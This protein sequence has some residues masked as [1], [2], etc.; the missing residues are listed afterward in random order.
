MAEPPQSLTFAERYGPWALVTGGSEGVGGSW[1]SAIAARGVNV[2]LL[3]RRPDVLEAKATELR[4]EHGVDVRTLSV[5]ITGSDLLERLDEVTHDL[6]V[7][8]LVHNVGSVERNHGWFLDDSLDVTVKTIGDYHT[9]ALENSHSALEGMRAVAG[10]IVFMG[11]LTGMAGQPLEA[12]YS[13]AKAFSQVFAEALWSE[14]VN[15]VDVVSVPSVVRARRRSKPRACSR[16]AAC[17]RPTKWCSKP[18]NISATGRCSCP[19]TPT[20]DGSTR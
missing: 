17:R 1:A 9:G 6:E 20:G 4:E 10:R 7:G 3:A 13:A 2:V 15:G 16:I 11:S 5:D 19:V 18:S 14:L 12:T 8:M